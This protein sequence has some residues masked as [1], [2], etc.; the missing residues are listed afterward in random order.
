MDIVGATGTTA[1]SGANCWSR[2]YWVTWSFAGADT[3]NQKSSNWCYEA[4]RSRPIFQFHILLDELS[5]SAVCYL[6]R[7]RRE[8]PF[9]GHT[10]RADSRHAEGE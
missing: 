7:H 8:K 1:C 2:K 9:E 4:Q 10:I 3:P 6:I 5:V